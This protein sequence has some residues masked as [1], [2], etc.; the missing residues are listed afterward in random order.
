MAV[1]MV[2]QTLLLRHTVP[3]EHQIL[4]VVAAAATQETRLDL[5]AE[6]MVVLVDLE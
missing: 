1:E 2:V 6:Q 5:L 3:L 4:V